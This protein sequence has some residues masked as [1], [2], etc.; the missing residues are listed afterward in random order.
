MQARRAAGWLG[1]IWGIVGLL[2]ATAMAQDKPILDEVVVTATRTEVPV[3]ELG[4]SATVVTAQEL[5]SQQTTDVLQALRGV[6]GLE[7]VQSGSRGAIAE[8]YTRGGESN[9]TLIMI[10][11]IRINEAGGGIDLSTLTADNV[12]RIEVIRG[13]QSALYGSDA[14]TG[15]INIITKRGR[16]EPRVTFSTSN[17]A[18]SENGHYTGEQKVGVSGGNDWAGYSFGYGRIDDRGILNINNAYENNTFSGRV[19]LYPLEKMDVTLT[20]RANLSRFGIPTENGGDRPDRVFPGLDPHQFQEKKDV[21]LGLGTRFEPFPWWEN[22]FLLGTR[23]LEQIFED[24][25]DLQS[26]FDAPPGSRSNSLETRT[27]FDYHT[28]FRFPREGA[29]RSILTL[30]FEYSREN[31]DLDS[32]STIR[33]GPLPFG[34]FTLL[35]VQ[36]A[37]RSN[38]AYYLQEQ[39]TILDRV[40]LTGGFRVDNNSEFGIQVSPRGSMAY[41]FKETG[42]KIRG[43]IGTGIKEPT[44]LENFGGFGTVG[45]PNLQPERSFSW[46]AGVDQYLWDRKAQIGVTYFNILYEDLIAYVF[47]P[48]PLISTYQNI[49]AAKSWGVEFTARVRPGMGF[50]LG[51]NYTFLDTEVLDDGGLG[52]LFFAK[53]KKLLRRPSHSGS[54]FVDWLWQNWNVHLQGT[55]VGKRDDTLFTVAPGPFGFYDFTTQRLTN[56]AYFVMDLAISYTFDL[57]QGPVKSMKFFVK[58]RNILND[59]YEEVLGYSSPRAAAMGGV[60][61]TF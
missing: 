46:E 3:A 27:S 60:E 43:A 7:V 41:E 56:D 17:G 33:F 52:N 21:I 12:E 9:F 1:G 10:D 20:A 11:G 6:T 31:L 45:N 42:T 58:G 50:T 8:V 30:G 39:L 16:G 49:Q 32:T 55:Y 54:L 47:Q 29:V 38:Y 48:P 40:F 61:F 59:Q 23:R 24:K 26:A 14:M 35:N 28:N 19:D 4:V 25:P 2:T 5:E 15:V 57:G 51:G 44:F 22:V 53:G 36:E 13:P 37:E 18:H 34:A